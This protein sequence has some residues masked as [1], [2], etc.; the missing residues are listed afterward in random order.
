[1]WT[2]VYVASP[3]ATVQHN[4]NLNTSGGTDLSSFFCYE[5]L[6]DF[7]SKRIGP[8]FGIKKVEPDLIVE[9][10]NVGSVFS[11][12]YCTLGWLGMIII[13]LFLMI[14]IS[15]YLL[16]LN[17]RST[18]YVTGVAILNTFVIFNFFDNMIAFSGLSLQLIFPLIGTMF[19]NK[20][21]L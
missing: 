17:K 16:L 15:F 19:V 20:S 1:M 14:I 6:P 4:I 9:W 7:I 13:F 5:L 10:S 8:L 2:Y 18:F 11:K 12:V 21:N 3:I